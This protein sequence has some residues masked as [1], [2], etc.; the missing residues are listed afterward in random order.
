[1]PLFAKKAA[2]QKYKAHPMKK[3]LLLAALLLSSVAQAET[4]VCSVHSNTSGNE[5]K[6]RRQFSTGGSYYDYTVTYPEGQLD[7]E[8]TFELAPLKILFENDAVLKLADIESEDY[9]V[10]VFIIQKKSKRF[11]LDG[12]YFSLEV[13]KDSGSCVIK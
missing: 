8:K 1:M 6:L 11:V 10:T 2:V 5:H 9:A 13:E 7:G 12:V 4:W 3:S